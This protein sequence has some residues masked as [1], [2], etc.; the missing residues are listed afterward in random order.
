M[1][2]PALRNKRGFTLVEVMISMVVLALGLLGSL[3]GVKAALDANYGSSLRMEATK[4]AQEQ[5]EMARNMP[6]AGLAA[7]PASQDVY[8]QIR[9]D[10]AKFIVRTETVPT[11]N[12][13]HNMTQ[14]TVNVSW[15]LKGKNHL[16]K[17]QTIVRQDK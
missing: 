5:V 13:A 7:I 15:T 2:L 4:V 10:N 1:A 17:V 12:T 3:V 11:A 16:Y 8:R 6:Y 14:L 9:K